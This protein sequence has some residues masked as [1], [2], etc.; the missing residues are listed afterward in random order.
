MGQ[1]VQ[2]RDQRPAVHLALVDL[3][4]AV[5]KPGRVAQTHGVG[6]REQPENGFG[7]MTSFWSSSVSLPSASS[8][9]WMTNITSA[10]PASYSSKT[11]AVGLRSARAG[12]LRGRP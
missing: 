1:I 4:G 10:R 8:T 5:V 9:R 3:L 2:R 7:V 12:C 6:G 11:M